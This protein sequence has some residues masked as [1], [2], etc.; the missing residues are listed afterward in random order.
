MLRTVALLLFSALAL[1]ACGQSPLAPAVRQPIRAQAAPIAMPLL[2]ELTPAYAEAQLRQSTISLAG[3]I[4]QDV[5]IVYI[6][7]SAPDKPK[8][9]KLIIYLSD[10]GHVSLHLG[11][12][13]V[14]PE[15]LELEKAGSRKLLQLARNYQSYA[16]RLDKILN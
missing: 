13:Y 7:S 9:G 8:Y 14:A 3:Y 2:P 15:P 4:T 5:Q 10:S 11:N 12:L 16:E 1:S 6:N